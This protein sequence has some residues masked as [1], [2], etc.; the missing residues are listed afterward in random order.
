MLHVRCFMLME[1]SPRY[2][3]GPLFVNRC[4]TQI[5][6]LKS[7]V[8]LMEEICLRAGIGATFSQE[9]VDAAIIVKMVKCCWLVVS[10]VAY[11]GLQTELTHNHVSMC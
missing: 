1:R 6:A 2:K 10:Q 5:E 3:K 9:A 7:F 4:I 11:K 8:I